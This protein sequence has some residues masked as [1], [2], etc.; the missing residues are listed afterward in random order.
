MMF[1]WLL[2]CLV[3]LSGSIK[4]E[5]LVF[6]E[7]DYINRMGNPEDQIW[8][9]II[10]EAVFRIGHDFEVKLESGRRPIHD[11]LSGHSDGLLFQASSFKELF[12]DLIQV[13]YQLSVVPLYLYAINKPEQLDICNEEVG[14]LEGFDNFAVRLST[15]FNCEKP[16]QPHYG[17]YLR[18]MIMMM[19]A[20]RLDWVVA[21]VMMEPFLNAHVEG[22]LY[23]LQASEINIPVFMYLSAHNKHLAVPLAEAIRSVYEERGIDNS[24]PYPIRMSQ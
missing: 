18:Q 15:L 13:E 20:E 16:M 9:E 2:C 24:S 23:R 4:A 17:S 10:E 19:Q 8:Y 5:T 22:D 3:L 6:S 12:P 1:R 21:P 11:A 7:F 14:M